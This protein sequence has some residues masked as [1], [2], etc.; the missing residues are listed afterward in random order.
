MAYRIKLFMGEQDGCDEVVSVPPTK[1]IIYPLNYQAREFIKEQAALGNYIDPESIPRTM[2]LP[3]VLMG[4]EFIGLDEVFTY[5]YCPEILDHLAE[6][7]GQAE[8]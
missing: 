5:E 7:E 3:Y 8:A 6:T 1:Q 2:R 4:V